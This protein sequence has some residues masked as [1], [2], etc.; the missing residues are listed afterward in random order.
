MYA[1][2]LFVT[3]VGV[4]LLAFGLPAVAQDDG[5]APP[6]PNSTT[7]FA[8]QEED[9]DEDFEGWMNTL[10][11]DPDAGAEMMGDDQ[12][13]F[14][15]V[16]LPVVDGDVEATWT[17][18]LDPELEETIHFQRNGTVNAVAFIGAPDGDGEELQVNTSLRA[19][20]E[21]IA[22]SN[23]TTLN[24]TE[25]G[26]GGF[27]AVEWNMTVSA[28]NVSAEEELVWEIHLE[29]GSCSSVSDGPYL[30][31]TE[32]RGHSRIDLPIVP[33]EPPIF[34]EDLVGPQAY[35]NVSASEPTNE[36][37]VFNWSA[38][39]GNY[40]ILVSGNAVNG[41]AFV[42]VLTPDGQSA[43]FLVDARSAM[44]SPQDRVVQAANGTWSI[45][46]TL[47]SFQGDV[48][49]SIEPVAVAGP[50]PSDPGGNGTFGGND[51]FGGNGTAGEPLEEDGGGIPGPGAALAAAAA[52]VAVWVIRRRE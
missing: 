27:V 48:T 5:P 18:T 13:C 49:V 36:S 7:L 17:L 20:D 41:T 4:S 35:A 46:V 24:Y 22:Q 39:S 51:T 52:L 50:G 33:P 6:S 45:N 40:G 25:A 2:T 31:V 26:D 14:G 47:A 16:A 29:G 8:H 38:D 21:V 23:V 32:T 19:G 12:S 34:Y 30:G 1:R 43:R 15:P 37:H 11:D 28:S 10:E 9:P 44:T 3:L 42:E